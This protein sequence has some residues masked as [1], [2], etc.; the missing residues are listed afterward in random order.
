ML[1]PCRLRRSARGGDQTSANSEQSSSPSRWAQRSVPMWERQEVKAVLFERIAQRP[2]NQRTLIAD[3]TSAWRWI[4]FSRAPQTNTRNVVSYPSAGIRRRQYA[5]ESAD[6]SGGV[7]AFLSE[8]QKLHGARYTAAT[9]IC[10]GVNA[11]KKNA[12]MLAQRLFFY[13]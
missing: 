10:T 7:S 3:F 5:G 8:S 2:Q 4:G 13:N 11:V 6:C 12:C 9:N 1:I